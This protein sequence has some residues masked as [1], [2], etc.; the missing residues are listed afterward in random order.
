[1]G[2]EILDNKYV[3]PGDYDESRF[4]RTVG[5]H[6]SRWGGA[7]LA[8]ILTLYYC[9]LDPATPLK[10]K[11]IIA[12]ALA[13]TVLPTD[14]IPDVLPAVGWG[15]DAAMI[16]WAGFEVLNSVSDDQRERPKSL[17][18]WPAA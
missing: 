3:E 6:A 17:I 11:T 14:L 4:W 2:E 13:Y 5:R 1:M 9:M 7:L 10:S 15:D 8:R 12:G 18:T 16:A